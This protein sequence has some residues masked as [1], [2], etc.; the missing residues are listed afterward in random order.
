MNSERTPESQPA[1]FSRRARER[2]SFPTCGARYC[3]IHVPFTIPPIHTRAAGM[4]TKRTA[5]PCAMCYAIDDDGGGG[6]GL[7]RWG[8]GR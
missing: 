8:A 5:V 1:T 6:F 4:K 7:A 2:F 3:S